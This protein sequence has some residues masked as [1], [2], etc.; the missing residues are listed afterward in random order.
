ML[1][2]G[3]IA[4]YETSLSGVQSVTNVMTNIY[5]IATADN[6]VADR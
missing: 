5:S 3:Y 4:A 2:A 1:P 6:F